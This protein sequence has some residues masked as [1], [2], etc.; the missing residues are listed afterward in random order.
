MRLAVGLTT[1]AV[2][3]LAA[4][5]TQQSSAD[6]FVLQSSRP[7]SSDTPSIPKEVARHILLQRTSRQRYGSDLR[8]I[9]NFVDIEATVAHLAA[10]GKTPAPLF[11]ASSHAADPAQLVVILEGAVAKQSSQLREKL[12]QDVAFTISDPPSAAA[13]KE[14][15]SQFQNLGIASSPQCELSAAINPF[16]ADCWTGSSSV[17]KYDLRTSP[18]TLDSL[19]DNLSRVNKFVADGDLEVLLVA[20]PESTRSSKLNHWSS[21]AA[22]TSAD[23][24]RRR[25]A[26]MVITDLEDDSTRPG[27]T[28]AP[29]ELDQQRQEKKPSSAPRAKAI[30]QCFSSLSRCTAETNSCSGHGE[31]VDKYARRSSAAS[32][33]TDRD[34][35]DSTGPSCFVCAC[36][37]SVIDRGDGARTPGRKT[38]HWGGNMCQKEDVSVQFWILAG[39]TILLVGAVTFAISLLFNVGEEKLPGVIGAGVSRSK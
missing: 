10:F 3:G 9:P 23:L 30:P 1:A 38:V 25:D 34:E 15:I 20:M 16:E 18:D 8:D 21:A 28:A 36:K 37:A 5:A 14:L 11:T 31:C 2:S 4:A 26:E 12:G 22:G 17:V 39:F 29:Q 6:V 13:N 24:R 33:L 19:F 7:S 32:P 27:P 35:G